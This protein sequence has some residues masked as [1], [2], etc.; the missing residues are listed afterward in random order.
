MLRKMKF[1]C[2]LKVHRIFH[3]TLCYALLLTNLVYMSKKYFNYDTETS[4]GFYSPINITSPNL[5]LCFDLNS[6]LGGYE[7]MMFH[8]RKPQYIGLQDRFLFSSVPGVHEILDKCA[9]RDA[10]L[11]RFAV[12]SNSSG[13]IND[14]N[15]KRY[16]MQSLMCYLFQVNRPR[17]FSFHS[18]SFSIN[19]P[20]LL[21]KLVIGAPL[22]TGHT[23]VLLVHFDELADVDRMFM[24]ELFPSRKNNELYYLE[25]DFFKIYRLPSPYS[26]KCGPDPFVRCFYDCIGKSY[27]KRGLSASTGIRHDVSFT[28]NTKVTDYS[29]TSDPEVRKLFED[30]NDH[31]IQ[32]V[33]VAGSEACEQKLTITHV[34]GPFENQA[35]KLTFIVGSFKYPINK[36]IHSAK[37]P[38]VEYLT[39]C[40]SLSGIW[41]GFS[42]IACFT[43]KKTLDIVRTS[44]MLIMIRSR[45]TRSL[46][47]PALCPSVPVKRK[48]CRKVF[49]KAWPVVLK[50]AVVLIFSGQ[51]INLCFLYAQY[52]T[53][54]HHDHIMNPEFEFVL[55]STAIC[56]DLTDL[57]AQSDPQGVN[58]GN[59]GSRWGKSIWVNMS[60]SQIFNQTLGEEMLF[61]CRTK[62]YSGSDFFKGIFQLKSRKECLEEF[63]FNKYYSNWQVCYLFTPKTLPRPYRQWKF[64]FRETNP[65]KLYSLILNPIAKNFKQIDLI[66]YFDSHRAAYTST[67]FRAISQKVAKKRTVM[68]NFHTEIFVSLPRPYDT[69]CNPFFTDRQC[70][71]DCFASGIGKYGLIPFRN[72]VLQG[73]NLKLLSYR[74]LNNVT[75]YRKW[76]KL[77]RNCHKRCLSRLCSTNFTLTYAK[78]LF[79]RTEFDVELVINVEASP[80]TYSESKPLFPFYDFYY[81][82]FCLLAFWLG[83]SFVSLD[84]IRKR[85]NEQLTVT[86]KL[87]YTE[88][89]KLLLFIGQM[90]KETGKRSEF[91]TKSIV[92][93]FLCN[94]ICILGMFFHLTIPFMEYFDYPTILLMTVTYEEPVGY[95]FVLCSE[96]Q[97]LY[98]KRIIFGGRKTRKLRP[99]SIFDINIDEI[100]TEAQRSVKLNPLCGYW[101]LEKDRGELNDMKKITDRIFFESNDSSLC[102]EMFFTQTVLKHGHICFQF[103]LRRESEWTRTQMFN[104]LN[105]IKTVL[106][107]SINSSIISSRFTVLAH[108]GQGFKPY[109]SSLW[110]PSVIKQSKDSRYVVSYSLYVVKPLPYPYS[111]KGFTPGHISHCFYQCTNSKLSEMHL[112]RS[113]LGE[114]LLKRRIPSNSL[115]DDPSINSL[116]NSVDQKCNKKCSLRNYRPDLKGNTMS[117]TVTLISE[118]K[119]YFGPRKGLTRFDLRRTDDPVIKMEFLVAMFIY[120]L[121]INVGSIISIWFGLSVINIP[122]LLTTNTTEEIHIRTLDNLKRMNFVLNQVPSVNGHSTV[123]NSTT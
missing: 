1:L 19:E 48:K 25:Y 92:K 15:I 118:A 3:R 123:K 4:V 39:Q 51:A 81:Q 55:P 43:H 46:I 104:T 52:R 31:C 72:T 49:K 79:G 10:T 109:H 105:E 111:D 77:E 74:Y 70:K 57:F 11:D 75:L 34:S 113:H 120:D 91:C 7:P 94:S 66:V 65:S 62:D 67:E 36:I 102:R 88:S 33:C 103:K 47:S 56:I 68:L 84:F 76:M 85:K 29:H 26:T 96:A 83:F 41:V 114:K 60:I 53:V 108:F 54:L 80:R 42:M 50:L 106:T 90:R 5:S 97:D 24:N 28:E 110:T 86:A 100:L 112:A 27:A 119:D 107:V 32:N 16:R 14:F 89:T 121:I 18:L 21:Y 58:E 93:K 17:N 116:I 82:V 73:S 87:L 35:D 9:Y 12:T 78:H 69:K 64:V 98:E 101:G 99:G 117:S 61:K 2:S 71:D 30:V 20:K 22:N 6:V 44:K 115:R 8:S 40:L 38:L 122:D 37:L 59:F 45:L 95:K 63:T 13:C 23:I